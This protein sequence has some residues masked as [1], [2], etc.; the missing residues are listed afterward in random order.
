MFYVS[1]GSQI[2]QFV[3]F[4]SNVDIVG[5]NSTLSLLQ[6]N[7]QC[8]E[9]FHERCFFSFFPPD[10]QQTKPQ[11]IFNVM[12]VFVI[13]ILA[14]ARQLMNRGSLVP[15]RTEQTR[16]LEE[17]CP[18]QNYSSSYKFDSY[19]G[20]LEARASRDKV[21]VLSYFDMGAYSM[22][23]N[24]YT[25]SFARNNIHNFL[26]LT[27]ASEVCD[28]LQEREIPCYVY[29]H[30]NTSNEASQYGSK[31]FNSKMNVR[32][33]MILEAL[34]LGYNVLHADVDMYF[35]KDPLP[36]ILNH[37]KEC[38]LVPLI[39]CGPYNEGF[40]FIRN[41][42]ASIKVYEI[43]KQFAE[44]GTRMHDQQA[45]NTAIFFLKPKE[46]TAHSL[47]KK[48]FICGGWY[49]KDRVFAG[50]NPCKECLVVH[51]NWIFGIDAKI[52]RFKEM[53]MWMVDDGGYYS[54]PSN[55]YI[56]YDSTQW[57]QNVNETW[58]H[59]VQ[60]MKNALAIGEILN[61]TVILPKPQ[62]KRKGALLCYT[63]PSKFKENF[64][65]KYRESTFLSHPLVSP[66]VQHSQSGIIA[67]ESPLTDLKLKNAEFFRP[68]S[69]T[70]GA[71][72]EEIRKWFGRRTESVLKF[73][74][75]YDGFSGFTDF[76]NERNFNMRCEQ[77]F[78]NSID[79][80]NEDNAEILHLSGRHS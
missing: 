34:K 42:T 60:A 27:S 4:K 53:H 2:S 8:G 78:K 17:C 35:F 33:Y 29:M 41:T 3:L 20:A 64:N 6:V 67:I 61:R 79:S 66:T 56:T 43:V 16:S 51:N 30:I 48:Q 21:I 47:P 32:T 7:G 65:D 71:T 45:L 25:T 62:S 73:N 9:M 70:K 59:E 22:G 68:S 44:N 19:K 37:C 58:R 14:S 36:V 26:F 80:D 31:D 77:T 23:L 24:F 76:E 54:D 75:L 10:S 74:Q 38:D 1:C 11:R 55:K 69:P 72:E 63:T 12:L 57:F 52:Y 18:S 28:L 15:G 49:F 13:T 46:L 40:L 5:Y 50:D 39:D